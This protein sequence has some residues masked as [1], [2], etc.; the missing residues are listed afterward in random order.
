LEGTFPET[1]SCVFRIVPARF[2]RY[3]EVRPGGFRRFPE[4]GKGGF[5]RFPERGKGGFRQYPEGE[6]ELTLTV[7]REYSLI[8]EGIS[9]GSFSL[10]VRQVEDY[11]R[12]FMNSRSASESRE[13]A[14]LKLGSQGRSRKP[15]LPAVFEADRPHGY[16][17]AKC[18]GQ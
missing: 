7:F 9:S 10:E 14:K 18:K 17:A 5:R 13:S 15:L 1:R 16:P 2:R 12:K 4:R 6:K 3:P 8:F 11:G